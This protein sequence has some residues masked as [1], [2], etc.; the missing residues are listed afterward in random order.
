MAYIR[1]PADLQRQNSNV[2]SGVLG[3]GPQAQGNAQGQAPT[4]NWT[5]LNDYINQNDGTGAQIADALN[6]GADQQINTAS[7]AGKTLADNAQK[8]TAA[9]IK[10]DQGYGNLFSTGSTQYLSNMGGEDKAKLNAWKAAPA[11]IGPNSV[12]K[13]SGYGDALSAT[14]KAKAEVGRRNTF[15]GQNIVAKE[16]LGKGNFTY[17]G[18]MSMLDNILARQAGGAQKLDALQARGNDLSLGF[19]KQQS[20]VNQS[21]A[22]SQ[23]QGQANQDSVNKA[24]Q[25]RYNSLKGTIT[26]RTMINESSIGDAATPEELAALKNLAEFGA[27]KGSEGELNTP[28]RDN[29]GK[30][31]AVQAQV[32]QPPIGSAAQSAKGAV[33]GVTAEMQA[34]EEARKADLAAAARNRAQEAVDTVTNMAQDTAQKATDLGSDWTDGQVVPKA[35]VKF[36]KKIK[37]KF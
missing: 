13:V 23:A 7:T 26:P 20:A 5:N 31:S 37:K 27:I 16:A 9:G 10:N 11:Y 36:G 34:V 25:D 19:E 33:P 2:Q 21:I 15:E 18:G 12:D 29:S 35:L 8:E 22:A 28:I 1:N 3:S 17:T 6:Q 24:I 14:D 4:S 32:V 30:P